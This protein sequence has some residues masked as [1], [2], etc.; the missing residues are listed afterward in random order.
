MGT[1]G[2]HNEVSDS[3][4]STLV[5]GPCVHE[6]DEWQT[7]CSLRVRNKQH[8]VPQKHD[9]AFLF[10]FPQEHGLQTKENIKENPRT[11]SLL[12]RSWN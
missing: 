6:W 3:Q 4:A 2:V 9:S 12:A 10:T 5:G 8:F 1:A 11:S 7:L